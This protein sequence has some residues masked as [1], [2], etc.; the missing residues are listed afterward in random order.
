MNINATLIGQIITF[1]IFIW[2]T[3]RYV[4]PPIKKAMRDREKNIANGLQAA[5]QG[6]RDLELAQRK[7]KQIIADAKLEASHVLERANERALQVVEEAKEEARV[8]GQRLLDN[9]KTEVEQQF[10]QARDQLR[11][12]VVDIALSGAEKILE[13]E[14]D[15][16]SHKKFL[17][18]LAGDLEK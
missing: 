15:K 10:N 18:E 2:F 8:E 9:A 14:V 16:A 4:W 6:R 12:E 7:S 1:A 17:Q 5:E 13:K 11:H 3:M